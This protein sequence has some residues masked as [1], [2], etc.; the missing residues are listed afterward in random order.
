[1]PKTDKEL[2]A[3]LVAAYIS[4]WYSKKD[5]WVPIDGEI[6]KNLLND[7]YSA[8]RSLPHDS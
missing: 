2:A 1:M 7:A 8:L 5:V 3:E 6:M 4:A